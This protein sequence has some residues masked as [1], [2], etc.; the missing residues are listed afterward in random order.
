MP[1]PAVQRGAPGTFVYVIDADNTVSVR[2]VKLGPPTASARGASG[3]QPGE[4]VVTDGAD[5]LR[6]GAAVT[7]PD[8]PRRARRQA[9][10]PARPAEP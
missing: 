7:V 2:P 3:L 10:R 4:R 8:R 9:G 6:D 1:V 5:R